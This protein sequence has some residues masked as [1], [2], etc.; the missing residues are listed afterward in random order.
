M[1]TSKG[2]EN[3]NWIRWFRHHGEPHGGEPAKARLFIGR[4]RSNSRQ[5]RAV[6]R[7]L[8][9]ILRFPGKTRRT[10]GRVI[11]DASSSRRSGAS[12]AGSQRLSK[13]SQAQRTLG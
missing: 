4:V 7:S 3:E 10:S 11:Y 5:S 12:G 13:S 1:A 2:S 6:A 9:N 8:R